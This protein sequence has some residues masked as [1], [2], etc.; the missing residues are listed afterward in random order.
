MKQLGEKGEH[1]LYDELTAYCHS[2]FYPFHMPGHK[3]R[4]GTLADPFTFDITE[5]EGFD[6]L[7]HAEGILLET[8]Q[9]AAAF[10]GSEET[11]FL[12]NGSTCGILSAIGACVPRGR[13]LMARNCHKAAYHAVY[14]NRLDVTY[15][16][17]KTVEER[18]LYPDIQEYEEGDLEGAISPEAVKEA[19][20]RD[21]DIRAVFITSPTYEGVVANVQSIARLAHEYGIPLIVDEAH[22]AHFGMHPIFPRSALA[23]GADVVIQSLHKTLPSLTQTALLHV[24]SSLVDR[25]RLRQMLGIYQSSSPSYV[26]MSSMDQCIRILEEQ[27]EKLFEAFAENLNFFYKETEKLSVLKVI[28]TDDPSKIIISAGKS[29]LSGKEISR[30]LREKYHLE[31]E[32]EA[33]SYALALTSV[34]DDREG[35]ERLARALTEMDEEQK[36]KCGGLGSRHT[37]SFPHTENEIAGDGKFQHTAA[38]MTIWEAENAPQERI[39]LTESAG[40]LSGEYIY[41]YPPGIPLVVPGERVNERILKV[42][43]RDK[44]LGYS[45]QGMEDYSMKYLWV[46]KE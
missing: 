30:I 44:E 37:A 6:N 40:Y 29:G 19:L 42:L 21:P 17:P 25:R 2:D 45:L 41:L 28:R 43:L 22:G 16:Y 35:F 33:V 20:S 9:R 32:M 1:Y 27:G 12:V 36:G 15:L 34:G 4:L 3:R 10:Y 11:H 23:Q 8:Q 7:H 24:N 38:E 31:M 5:I 18:K 46:V 13:I 14:L 26:L 39:L